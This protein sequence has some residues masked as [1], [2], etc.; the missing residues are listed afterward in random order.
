[1]T[2]IKGSKQ[3]LPFLVRS[4]MLTELTHLAKF[5]SVTS[6]KAPPPLGVVNQMSNFVSGQS[7]FG[8]DEAKQW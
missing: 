4:L 2:R 8:S 3:Q 7:L 6:D 5:K 1:M